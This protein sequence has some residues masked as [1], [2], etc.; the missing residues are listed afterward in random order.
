MCVCVV[1]GSVCVNVFPCAY[2]RVYVFVRSCVALLL[3]VCVVRMGVPV[4]VWCVRMGAYMLCLCG[5]P[6]VLM[7]CV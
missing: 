7:C 2:V 1:V 5:F 6:V 4:C 3:C